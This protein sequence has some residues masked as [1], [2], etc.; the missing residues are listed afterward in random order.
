MGQPSGPSPLAARE[1][2]RLASLYR[3]RHGGELAEC[4]AERRCRRV[5]GAWVPRGVDARHKVTRPWP[6]VMTALAT[7]PHAPAVAVIEAD[8]GLGTSAL[9]LRTIDAIAADGE[10]GLYATAAEL[11]RALAAPEARLS[12]A[13][14]A[15]VARHH[16]LAA[17]AVPIAGPWWL[18]IDELDDLDGAERARLLAAVAAAGSL[19]RCVVA[20]RPGGVRPRGAS[21]W[22]LLPFDAGQRRQAIE[23]RLDRIA[24]AALRAHAG[25]DPALEALLD[26]PLFCAAACA[27]VGRSGDPRALTRRAL[28]R[29]SLAQPR[30]RHRS[31]DEYRTALAL[32]P[33]IRTGDLDALAPIGAVFDAEA[34]TTGLPWMLVAEGADAATVAAAIR[35]ERGWSASRRAP[36]APHQPDR[37]VLALLLDVWLEAPRPPRLVVEALL[38]EVALALERAQRRRRDG[39]WTEL[40]DPSLATA[41]LT[42]A[43]RSRVSIHAAGVLEAVRVVR[44][45]HRGHDPGLPP[46]LR[47]RARWAAVAGAVEHGLADRCAQVRWAALWAATA[48][49]RR[50]D[51]GFALVA[52][53]AA[54]LDDTSASVRSLACRAVVGL[55]HVDAPRLIAAAFAA[56]RCRDTRAGA[57]VALGV[58]ATAEARVALLAAADAIVAAPIDPSDPVPAAV[59][60]ALEE[61][62]DQLA[63]RHAPAPPVVAAELASRFVRALDRALPRIG[64]NAASGLGKIGDL[65]ACDALM[66]P[67]AERS[68]RSDP[69]ARDPRL[70]TSAAFALDRLCLRFAHQRAAELR[71]LVPLLRFR[72]DDRGASEVRRHVA[73]A[74]RHLAVAGVLDD[75]ALRHLAAQAGDDDDR[76]AGTCILAIAGSDAGRLHLAAAAAADPV[77]AARVAYLA[78]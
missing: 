5:A 54:L 25:T 28:Y 8:P 27:E 18:A 19:I 42:L 20:M 2:G 21:V 72:L 53:A 55:G 69:A 3:R 74:L 73:S 13:V 76:V 45:P 43:A 56:P 48:M 14:I 12:D 6:T 15:C 33:S 22:Q 44:S 66:R 68:D 70:E 65:D 41:A 46:A 52:R 29:A 67:L 62:A 34:P 4:L 17:D 1:R 50:G 57:A 75:G 77:I 32:A 16:D 38:D 30:L 40:D 31:L 11:V 7:D 10:H 61:W 47:D 51:P 78:S 37:A 60:A 49:A 36:L 35:R 9:L 39:S 63:R 58:V 64:A 59:F 23:R 26:V 24:A 71:A